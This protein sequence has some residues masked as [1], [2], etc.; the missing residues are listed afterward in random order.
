MVIQIH[1]VKDFF[2][3]RGEA[4]QGFHT[5]KAILQRQS[6]KIY[7]CFLKEIASSLGECQKWNKTPR[8]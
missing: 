8:V 5:G 3:T 4:R 6:F 7:V 2:P 1:R